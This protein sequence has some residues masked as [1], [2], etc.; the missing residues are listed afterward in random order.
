MA[1]TTNNNARQT[2]VSPGIYTKEVDLTYAA[3]SL[4]IT[5]LGVVGETVKGPAFQPILVDSW[6]TYQN[7]FG[8]TST[9]KFRGS[10][11]PKYELP[12]IAKSYLEESQ[13]LQVCRV[14]GLSGV[15]AGAAWLLTAA[16]DKNSVYTDEKPLVIGVLRSRGEHRKAAFVKPMDEP[17]GICEDVYEYDKIVYFAKDVKITQS[18]D[19]VLGN[20]CKPGFDQNKKEFTM[21]V[22]NYGTFTFV[23]TTNEGDEKK[24]SV[25]LNPS[26]KNYIL[27]VLG[28]HP[29]KG[30]TEIYV[31]ELYDVAIQ[32]LIERGEL[33]HL[34]FAPF[35][36]KALTID[37][38]TNNFDL[39]YVVKDN[40]VTIDGTD[41]V[42]EGNKV[43]LTYTVSGDEIK[44]KNS[45][46]AF[47]KY[48]QFSLDGN[49]Y[50][51]GFGNYQEMF[52]YQDVKIVPSHKPVYDLLVEDESMLTRR[53][54]GRRYLYSSEFSVNENNG[55]PLKVHV[56]TDKGKTWTAAEGI[57]GH[58]YTV[59]PFTKEDGSREY[60]YGEYASTK[61]EGI[62]IINDKEYSVIN[63]KVTIGKTEYTVVD[64]KVT[65]GETE[66]TVVLDTFIYNEKEYPV[67]NGK[68]TI[69][70]T[71]YTVV[72]DKVTIGETEYTVVDGKVTIRRVL[73]P[74]FEKNFETEWLKTE[75]KLTDDTQVFEDAVEVLS[76]NLTYI[77]T[78]D[79][80]KTDVRPVT[81]DF[82]NYKEA[83]RYASTPWIVSEMKGSAE[84]VELTKLFRFHTISDGSASNTEVKVSLAN[85]D[86][87]N[88]TFDVLV[89]SFYDTDSAPVVL[90][91]YTQCN[92]IPGSSNYI[93][94]KIG[95]TNE[96]YET[97]SNYIT[98][99]VNET[100][101]TK[102]SVPAGFLGY[103]VRCFDGAMVNIGDEKQPKLQSPYFQYNTNVDEE[104]RINKQYFGISDLTG[105]DED[106]LRYKGVEAY[107]ELPEGLSPCFHLDSRILEEGEKTE[108]L[109]Q[110]VTVDGIVYDNWVTVG[111]SNVTDYGIE[112]RLGNEDTMFGTIYEDKRYRKF[113]VAFY[114]GWDGW[115]Y[116]RDQRSND[117][118]F[119]YN[120]Y[121]GSLNRISGE[122][123]SFSVIRDPE[124]YGFDNKA[125][126]SDYYA[127]LYGI[128]QFANPKSIDI[129]VFATPGIDY[130]NNK[131]LVEEAIEMIET[132]RADSVYV[133]TTPDKPSG[134]GDGVAEMYTPYDAVANLEDSEIDS[135][136]ACTYYPWVKYFDQDNSQYI[137]LPVTK[138]I[139]RN[140]AM[141]DNTTY[142]WFAAAGWN[143]GSVYGVKSKRNLKLAEQDA[144]YD[145][146]IN[147]INSFPDEG[148]KLWG[149]KNLQERESQMNRISKRR[150]LV[151]IRKLLAVACV[152]LLFD[153][154]DNSTVKSFKSAVEP[155]LQDIVK[156]R[157]LTDFRIEI[158]D[159]Q[160][161]RDRLELNGKIYLKLQPNLE[162]IDLSLIIT[163]SGISFDDI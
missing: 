91:R 97:R 38:E 156:K 135:N 55:S 4:G 122:G 81:L 76:V 13:Q 129:N 109:Q 67:I 79:E 118:S 107:N 72:E 124:A 157:G 140:F 104:I 52:A 78:V 19:L 106:I 43:K 105:I 74:S 148:M 162:Y 151:H 98:V 50:N 63:G 56:S 96:D 40:K 111:K 102:V 47:I 112:P 60:Y 17:A 42:V 119:T 11:Y 6:R 150:L 18:A 69:G 26:N 92:L 30:D 14:L 127:Y 5:T 115:D 25:T 123:I 75:H 87:E 142:P 89:R 149:D 71:E 37:K 117:D 132:E 99:E 134:A 70:E 82:N 20:S 161:A 146:R 45:I 139:V 12:Y 136:Y 143:R 131:S 77:A 159:S 94:Y 128:R 16:G 95:S 58:I 21:D 155:I 138:D 160:E 93:A 85:I 113:T 84:N 133:I 29:S 2:H 116:F 80:G 61:A 35:K 86:P 3:K 23:V 54:V 65:I 33:T 144:L 53:Y 121:R 48:D 130:V 90:E 101:K 9:E 73:Y 34:A 49:L 152:G 22:L 36:G 15:N 7:Y 153:P 10:Q 83:Y 103:P 32:Q 120:K 100:D 51:T 24:Y 114:G 44:L 154:N 59:V 158:D 141:T 147:F 1:K 145:G 57:V 137:Y 110:T 66:Y 125:I 41:Y 88:G 28:T 31:E 8:G 39:E 64:G 46:K 163:P 68:V 126:T 27:N 108:K 62:V